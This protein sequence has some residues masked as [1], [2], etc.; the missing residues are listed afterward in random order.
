L[1]L[2]MQATFI[3]PLMNDVWMRS[4]W[5]LCSEVVFPAIQKHALHTPVISTRTTRDFTSDK[6]G[7]CA[8]SVVTQVDSLAEHFFPLCL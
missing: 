2:S 1:H 4:I 8:Q 6:L 5:H 7:R 3:T